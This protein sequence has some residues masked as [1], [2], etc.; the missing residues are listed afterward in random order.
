MTNK[1]IK[2]LSFIL[3]SLL[4]L[5]SI[6]ANA[7]VK[8]GAYFGNWS[9]KTTY[10]AGDLIKYSDK[11]FLSLVAKNKNKN[12]SST[13]KAWQLLGGAGVAGVAGPI[14]PQGVAGPIGPQ[15]VAG[16]VGGGSTVPGAT[17]DGLTSDVQDNLALGEMV[18]Q[19]C[20]SNPYLS[21]SIPCPTLQSHCPSGQVIPTSISCII[22]AS[23]DLN[24]I[25]SIVNN[26]SPYYS[27]LLTDIKPIKSSDTVNNIQNC[28]A[29]KP[30]NPLAFS[31]FPEEGYTPWCFYK[32]GGSNYGLPIQSDT[33]QFPLIAIGTN[34]TMVNG[35]STYVTTAEFNAP[36]NW[37]C[38]PLEIQAEAHCAAI[39]VKL[40]S[41]F[42]HFG[43][44]VK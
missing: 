20:D 5:T 37:Q 10:G 31:L 7:V 40:K 16:V 6:S 35:G 36:N 38:F 44:K 23:P 13:P 33:S 34:D 42:Q 3:A 12:P 26:I 2:Q 8:V 32:L 21:S 1:L 14:G 25:K 19:T 30:F 41:V 29:P 24:L 28:K 18:T 9:A 22:L 17:I 4:L 15:G 11:T 43:I 27:V 39:P